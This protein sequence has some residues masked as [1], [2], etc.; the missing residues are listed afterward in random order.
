[1]LVQSLIREFHRK[2]TQALFIK[3]DI[4]KAFDSVSWAYLLEVL[5]RLGF[6]P[7]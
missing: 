2:K 4:T 7:K 6:G 3:V 1:M 5:Q